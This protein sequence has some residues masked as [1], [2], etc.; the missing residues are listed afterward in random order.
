MLSCALW[1][2]IW[3]GLWHMGSERISLRED[4]EEE[5]AEEDE[6]DEATVAV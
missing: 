6:E 2:L 3:I 1:K 4:G 5:D